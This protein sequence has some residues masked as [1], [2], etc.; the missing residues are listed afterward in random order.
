M[1][2]NT[3]SAAPVT[4]ESAERSI[5]KTKIIKEKNHDHSIDHELCALGSILCYKGDNRTQRHR[6]SLIVVLHRDLNR[7][8]PS[9]NKTK[10]LRILRRH[11]NYKRWAFVV[12]D[13][14]RGK[15]G[16]SCS[17]KRSFQRHLLCKVGSLT[18]AVKR[19]SGWVSMKQGL[20]LLR[21]LAQT[22][23]QALVNKRLTGKDTPPPYTHTSPSLPLCKWGVG[24]LLRCIALH[25][26]SQG[27]GTAHQGCTGQSGHIFFL[28]PQI[29]FI[30]LFI[31]FTEHFRFMALKGVKSS[32]QGHVHA[33]LKYG[34]LLFLHTCLKI[35]LC[36]RNVCLRQPPS[37]QMLGTVSPEFLSAGE[38]Y[39]LT[40]PMSP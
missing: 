25:C 8:K 21:D 23:A 32:L 3:F 28:K 16:Y 31:K 40:H 7:W 37:Q 15:P 35:S 33:N 27:K 2:G 20:S 5:S 1:S 13:R 14:V 29:K 26:S 19:I 17:L 4:T 30:V 39:N 36:K 34:S 9:V 10:R 38:H 11:E 24:C 18:S 22:W 6:K 12:S